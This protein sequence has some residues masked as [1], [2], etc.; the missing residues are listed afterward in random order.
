MKV[1]FQL[2]KKLLK[3]KFDIHIT[4][5]D[6]TIQIYVFFTFIQQMFLVIPFGNTFLYFFNNYSTF[7]RSYSI[8]SF[9]FRIE[10]YYQ[11][12]LVLYLN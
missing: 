4:I 3:C 2:T 12:I 9:V 11:T 6:K 7:D 8:E 5:L 1:L 10:M